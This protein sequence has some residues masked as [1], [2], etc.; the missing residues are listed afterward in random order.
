MKIKDLFIVFLLFQGPVFSQAISGDDFIS[1]K[2]GQYIVK[3]EVTK[4]YLKVSSS[5]DIMKTEVTQRM[6]FEVTGFNPS[7]FRFKKYCS[8]EHLIIKKEQLCPNHPVESITNSD[9][10]TF[11]KKLNTSDKK[12]IYRLPTHLEWD[13]AARGVYRDSKAPLDYDQYLNEIENVAWVKNNSKGQTHPVALKQKNQ[14]GA[15]D[16]RGNIWEI[17]GVSTDKEDLES[18]SFMKV[19]PFL[20]FN[21]GRYLVMK[22]GPWYYD[23][24]FVLLSEFSMEYRDVSTN[25]MGIRL[26]RALK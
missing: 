19:N 5:F 15:H 25:V 17:L 21:K 26:V 6:F 7:Y 3:D 1:V 10:E 22:G 2:R 24:N 14:I 23:K 13:K 18:F 8:K 4:Y 20:E 11:L 9:I 16:F 12:Y